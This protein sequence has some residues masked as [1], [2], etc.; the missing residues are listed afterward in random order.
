MA[1]NIPELTT[2]R[3]LLRGPQASDFA[4]YEA[5]YS[6]AEASKFYDGPLSSGNAWR[7][8]A[9]DLGHWQLRGFGR[10]SI[11]N[12][13]NGEMVG[14][15]GLW[16]P[17]GWPRSELTWWI[18][19]EARRMGFASEASRS[20]IRFGYEDLGWDLVETHM[21]DDNLAARALV[22]RLGGAPIIRELFPDGKERTVYSLPQ[23]QP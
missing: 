9:M 17:E 22:E 18:M 12:R 20:A 7:V 14:S 8:L 15:C 11:V 3:L 16:W 19:P 1:S 4:T 6:D 5:F 21:D 13:D 2:E 23:N 10:W